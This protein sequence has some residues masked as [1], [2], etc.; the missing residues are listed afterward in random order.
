[1]IQSAGTLILFIENL[2]HYSG[3]SKEEYRIEIEL[4]IFASEFGTMRDVTI[5]NV[6]VFGVST[7]RTVVLWL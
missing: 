2:S 4:K 7:T 5:C 3:A 6:I 1:M